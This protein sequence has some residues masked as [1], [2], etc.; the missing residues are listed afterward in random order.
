MDE[1]ERV[2][3]AFKGAAYKLKVKPSARKP[4]REVG[5]QGSADAANLLI[6]QNT[7][8]KQ[9][10][11]HEQKRHGNNKGYG[12]K[13]ICADGQT[14][15]DGNGVA[16][17]ALRHGDRKDGQSVTENK[18]NGGQGRGV[19]PLKKRAPPLSLEITVAEKRV[20]KESPK[21]VTPGVRCEISKSE[22]GMLA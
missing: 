4:R 2:G 9:T 3:D 6:V 15:N 19:K 22:T 14:E 11:S 13:Y 10:H 8:E 5:E 21:T 18:I 1:G 20:I 12:K 7:A 17:D 16:D